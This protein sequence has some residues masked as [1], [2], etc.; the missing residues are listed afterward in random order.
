[1]FVRLPPQRAS[2]RCDG[3]VRVGHYSADA[4]IPQVGRTS[5]SDERRGGDRHAED[6][7]VQQNGGPH[8]GPMP[9]KYPGA[10]EFPQAELQLLN[11]IFANQ[12]AQN[13]SCTWLPRD[14][15]RKWK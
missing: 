14:A 4:E 10:N 1:M 9:R 6:L 15:G 13:G 2:E 11:T 5:E 7:H 3:L 8:G 12:V